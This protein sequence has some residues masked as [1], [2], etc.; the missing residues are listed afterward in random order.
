MRIRNCICLV[1]PLVFLAGCFVGINQSF[2]ADTIRLGFVADA[3]GVGESW[4]KS[5]RAGIDLFIEQIN[6]QGGVLGKK[7]ELVVRD[8]ALKPEQGEAAAEDLIVKDKCDFLIGPTSSGVALTVTKVAKKHKKIVMFHTSNS[9]TLTTTDYQPYMFQVVPN[10]GIESRG[11]AHFFTVRPY[12]RFSYLGPDYAYARNWWENFKGSITKSRPDAEIVSEQWVKLGV[13]DF[14]PYIPRIVADQPEIIITNLWGESLAKFIRQIQPTGLLQKASVTSLFD[15]EMLKSM[16]MDMPEG[17]LGY[18]RCAFYAV[19][20]R[21]MKDFVNSFQSKYHDVP[22]DWAIMAYDGLIALTE[23]IKKANTIDSDKVVQALEGLHYPSLRGDR[24]IR[25][26]D[27]MADVGIYVGYTGKDKLFG[28]GLI[29]KNV[30]YVPA[31]MVWLPVDQVK[32]LQSQ[33]R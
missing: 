15:L 33:N 18:S 9:E 21:R 24:H 30:V 16:G 13:T 25:A 7:L 28:Q 26:E 17:I 8:A 29:L 19:R 14:S 5:Q 20:E 23:A 31:D 11:L 22:A 3:T 6:A 2:A 4:Y 12:K 32:K 27:H 10:T 1:I